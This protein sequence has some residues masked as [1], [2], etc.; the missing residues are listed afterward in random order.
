MKY[1]VEKNI[2]VII[3]LLLIF[4]AQISL[5]NEAKHE[6]QKWRH[7]R[8]DSPLDNELDSVFASNNYDDSLE[9]KHCEIIADSELQDNE[10]PHNTYHK[11]CTESPM[12]TAGNSVSD[13]TTQKTRPSTESYE[14]NDHPHES[15]EKQAATEE[16]QQKNDEINPIVWIIGIIFVCSLLSGRR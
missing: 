8:T 16:N 13:D 15:N 5:G 1:S 10:L 6:D 14:K 3:P 2:S 4:G 9:A 11:Y 7:M 12:D